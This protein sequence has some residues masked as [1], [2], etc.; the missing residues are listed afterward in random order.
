MNRGR[1][2][3]TFAGGP[4]AVSSGNLE[5]GVCRRSGSTMRPL[6]WTVA[7]LVLLSCPAVALRLTRPDPVLPHVSRFSVVRPVRVSSRAKRSLPERQEYPEELKYAL[8][9]EGKN[10][11][12]Q[13][14]KNRF[15]IGNQYTET[16]YLNNGT[17]VTISPNYEDHCYYHGHVEDVEDS[18]VSVG[19]CSG[20]RGFMR[21][22]QSVYLIEPLAGSA[23]GD[24][25]IYRPENLRSRRATCGNDNDTYYDH[26]PRVS[27]VFKSSGWKSKPLVLQQRFV[28]MFMVVDNAEYQKYNGDLAAIKARMLEIA[29]HVDKLYRPLNIR[30]MLVGLEIWSNNDMIDV[31]T[32]P[33]DTLTSFISWRNNILIKKT[34]HDNA[35]FITGIDFAGDTVGLANKFAM[36][37]DGS[38]AV[39]QDHNLNPIG[40]AS[41]IAHE[42]GHNLGMSHDSD[43]CACST[44]LSKNCIMA[45]RVGKIYPETF[46]S[47]S[48]TDLKNFL[49]KVNPQCLLDKPRPDKIFGGAVCG[50]AFLEPGEQCDC[51]TVEH[52]RSLHLISTNCT[53]TTGST[54]F[55]LCPILFHKFKQAGSLCR[56]AA[57]ECD[58]AEYCT[59]N[60]AE[61]PRNVFKMNGVPCNFNQ[62]YCYNGQC[63]TL[64]QHCEKLWG[65]G[66]IVAPDTCFNLNTQ[67]TKEAYCKKTTYSYSRCAE[68]DIKCGKIFCTGGEQFP[69]TREKVQLTTWGLKCN[70]AVDRRETGDLGMVPMGTKCGNNK[71]CYENACQDLLVYGTEECSAKCNNH[72]VCNHEKQCHCDP[73]WAPPYCDRTYADIGK[74]GLN[75][76]VIS[77]SVTIGILMLITLVVGGLMCCRKPQKGDYI[78]KKKV[79]NASGLSNPMFRDTNATGSLRS[80]STNISSPTFVESSFSQ[81]CTPLAV[82]VP[83]HP[84]PEPPK[85]LPVKPSVNMHQPRSP[86]MLPQNKVAYPQAKPPPPT[87]PLPPL[88]VKQASQPKPP[89]PMPPLKMTGLKMTEKQDMLVRQNVALKPPAKPR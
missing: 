41:T 42:M 53:L 83:S 81:A 37:L 10:Y 16:H 85:K 31:S 86:P 56:S 80:K 30:V 40:V 13:L 54:A 72:G 39:N 38:G 51:G 18:A 24:H 76:V 4:G 70:V 25:A 88:A 62:G 61:C 14:E 67:G 32:N 19:I 49:E 12:L 65:S 21:A 55:E 8:S 34:K 26:E 33:D 63:P 23:N 7:S 69:I 73:G 64:Q 6:L 74:A 22:K 58:L 75:T 15:L 17:K 82:T 71:V 57:H 29:N 66:A 11:T 46:S 89:P 52:I 20:I 87:K 50:N 9:I 3:V 84:P 60:T 43:Y 2:A 27:E 1:S 44:S 77:V 68:K 48:Q 59:G 47:C 36:C 78:S 35:Q 28:E 5:G 79:Q 45:D